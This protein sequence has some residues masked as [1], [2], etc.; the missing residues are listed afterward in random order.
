[1]NLPTELGNLFDIPD[2][3]QLSSLGSESLETLRAQGFKLKIGATESTQHQL[4][5]LSKEPAIREY[6]PN[7]LGR[8]FGDEEMFKKWLGK[9]RVLV[10][11]CAGDQIVGYGWTG[12]GKSNK[13]SEGSNT[14]AIRLGISA[15]GKGLATPFARLIIEFSNLIFGLDNFWLETWQSNGG[16]VHIYHKIGFEDVTT[17]ESKRKTADGSEVDDVRIY[18]RLPN[19]KLPVNSPR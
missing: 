15:S 9:G 3:S 1:M 5:A 7:D 19:E 16:A 17:E 2:H 6:C 13:I 4:K 11:L 8:R 10:T 14:F 18:M 12:E